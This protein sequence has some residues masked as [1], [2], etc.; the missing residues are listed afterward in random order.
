[1]RK[2]LAVCAVLAACSLSRP[3]PALAEAAPEA[4]GTETVTEALCRMIEGAARSRALPV[5]FFTRLIWRESSFRTNVTSRAGAQGVAQFMP[6]TAAE[7]G[8]ANPFDPEQAIPNPLACCRTCG[9][10]SAI[11]AWPPQ[12]TTAVRHGLRVG[13]RAGMRCGRKRVNT[14]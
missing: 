11:L 4:T 9:S 13:W 6:G 1:M 14:C 2:R 3:A 7:R 5:D 12:P 10:A 8:L